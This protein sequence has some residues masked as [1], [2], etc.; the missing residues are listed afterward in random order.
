MRICCVATALAGVEPG[1]V[2]TA[3]RDGW[4][5]VRPLDAVD[6]V[7]S[8]DGVIVPHVGTGLAVV[9]QENHPHAVAY[10][11]HGGGPHRIIW[12][13]HDS[14][15]ALIDLA[16]AAT[17]N[18]G[19]DPR[20]SSSFLGTDLA[21]LKAKNVRNLHL[22]LPALMCYS[23]LGRGFLTEISGVPIVRDVPES[24]LYQ[25]IRQA[26]EFLA[27]MSLYVT[28]PHEQNL[29]G[30]DGLAR[31][32]QRYGMAPDVAQA[33]G[34]ADAHTI[35]LLDHAETALNAPLLTAAGAS[36]HGFDGIGGGL[37]KIFYLLRAKLGV[38]GEE[39]RLPQDIADLYIYVTEKIDLH[40]PRG[41]TLMAERAEEYG[42]PAIAIVSNSQL[43]R[44][45][46]P[47]LGI[48][49]LYRIST[50]HISSQEI[51][52][53]STRLATTWGWDSS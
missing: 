40:I 13:D 27:D 24:T 4:K 32:W 39:L 38:I 52:N 5:D 10:E 53:L 6:V 34:A 3:I 17:W 29:G 26:R 42:A 43:V 11:R 23:D 49:G 45:E 14:H 36:R 37:G 46:L 41:L 7:V 2:A 47:K 20:G 12:V 18:G 1:A 16:E 21:Y 9:F 19:V 28:Y 50:D 25:A 30:I 22:H 8:S 15:S 51:R 35:Q 31:A 33:T 48:H 44:G